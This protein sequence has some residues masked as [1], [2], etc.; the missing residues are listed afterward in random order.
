[1]SGAILQLGRQNIYFTIHELEKWASW[2][3]VSLFKTR[4]LK[5]NIDFL[6]ERN[7]MDDNTFF[8]ALGFSSVESC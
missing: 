3:G 7:C 1:M 6:K 8:T 2:H 4:P 5:S